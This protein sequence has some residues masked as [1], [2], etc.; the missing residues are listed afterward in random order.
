MT[1]RH[2]PGDSCLSTETEAR[3]L[4]TGEIIC[5][6]CKNSNFREKKIAQVKEFKE[7]PSKSSPAVGIEPTATRL[8]A[9]FP[10]DSGTRVKAS[11]STTELSGRVPKAPFG[12]IL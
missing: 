3:C 4:V 1:L 2:A 5:S 6:E 7:N 8:R 12:G 10:I 11:R 9:A